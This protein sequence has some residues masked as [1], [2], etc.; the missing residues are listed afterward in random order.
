MDTCGVC[1]GGYPELYGSFNKS[2]VW[3]GYCVLVALHTVIIYRSVS[4]R[5]DSCA[6]EVIIGDAESYAP[7]KE[8]IAME[9]NSEV[10]LEHHRKDKLSGER[11]QMKTVI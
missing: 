5:F 7:M 9:K 1:R 6:L 4:L 10:E 2:K 8:I 3:W 11:T